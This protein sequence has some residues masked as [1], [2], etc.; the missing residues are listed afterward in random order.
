MTCLT[1]YAGA[2]GADL[3]LLAA[4]VEH[5]AC[6]DANADCVAT[7]RAAGLPGI[8]AGIGGPYEDAPAF[9]LS[10]FVG[11]DLVWASPPC[12]PYSRAGK[13]LGADDAR[14]GWPHTLA[15]LATLRPR[16]AVVENVRGAPVETWAGEL[17]A[18]SL[19][20]QDGT[21]ADWLTARAVARPLCE[22]V[23][24]VENRIR[25]AGFYGDT[26]VEM[27]VLGR[28]GRRHTDSRS[29]TYS[30]LR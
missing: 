22:A 2:G 26:A 28:L 11:V 8:R 25:A 3:G 14:D 4:G 15:I 10:P 21:M 7:L 13:G 19:A 24:A 6:V 20:S 30:E 23:T 5:V 12:Q 17:R 16:W 18:V 27:A 9:D 29:V 1:L